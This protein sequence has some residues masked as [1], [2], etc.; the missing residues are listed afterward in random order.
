MLDCP[1]AFSWTI[2]TGFLPEKT[3]I[4]VHCTINR[5]EI[6]TEFTEEINEFLDE[7]KVGLKANF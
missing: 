6:T 5:T 7:W 3:K 4:I 1:N 2:T